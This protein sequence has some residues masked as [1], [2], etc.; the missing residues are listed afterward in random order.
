MF[1]ENPMRIVKKWLTNIELNGLTPKEYYRNRFKLI[2]EE[3]KKN[4]ER[5]LENTIN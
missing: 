1:D 3:I 5:F 2:L 4:K